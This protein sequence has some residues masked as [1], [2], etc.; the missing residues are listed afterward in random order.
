[1]YII[2]QFAD[3]AFSHQALYIGR[4]LKYVNINSLASQITLSTVTT[5]ILLRAYD[6]CK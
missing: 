6:T 2:L 5:V 4:A 1:M 3:D